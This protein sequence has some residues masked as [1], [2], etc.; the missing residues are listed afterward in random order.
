VDIAGGV[1][2]PLSFTWR[3][4]MRDDM[5]KVLV[6]TPRYGSTMKNQQVG[7]LRREKITQDH[8]GPTHA[9]MRPNAA[10]YTDRKQLNENLSPL[11][12]Y[13]RKNCG[14]PWDKIYSEIRRKNPLG[15][16]VTEHIYQHL[17]DF[18]ELNPVIKD[19]IPYESTGRYRIYRDS[20]PGFYVNKAGIL[21]QPKKNR[22]QYKA[23]KNPRVIKIDDDSYL[24][25]RKTDSVWFMICYSKPV[26]TTV[27]YSHG[28][29][30]TFDKKPN[31]VNIRGLELPRVPGKYANF[32]KT[33]SR[34]EKKTYNL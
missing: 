10:R 11:L 31:Q 28:E 24:V 22:P 21:I 9:S 18:V 3:S 5:K 6:T 26:R 30:Y 29:T 12:R 8:E 1:P 7:N 33:L 2:A 13:L 17:F 25:Q 27:T 20:W 32:S 34:R 4:K 19:N 23:P 14:K 16:A 15:N